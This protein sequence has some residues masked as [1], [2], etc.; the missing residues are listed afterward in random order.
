MNRLEPASGINDESWSQYL[1][2]LVY[3]DEY[4]LEEGIIIK[5]ESLSDFKSFIVD[6]DIQS[7]GSVVLND[8][9]CYVVDWEDENGNYIGLKFSGNRDIVFVLTAVQSHGRNKWDFGEALSAD[10][11]RSSQRAGFR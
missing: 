3:L 10:I 9:G 8:E 1:E 11:I 5:P 4:S 2:R 6:N 7:R